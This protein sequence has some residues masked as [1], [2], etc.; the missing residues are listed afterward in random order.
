[1]ST[2]QCRY[3]TNNEIGVANIE[4]LEQRLKQINTA[5]DNFIFKIGIYGDDHLN[6]KEK[7]KYEKLISQKEW[8]ENQLKYS[9]K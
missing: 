8:I 4:R 7:A 2:L 5:I 9:Q 6:A 3:L 1:M